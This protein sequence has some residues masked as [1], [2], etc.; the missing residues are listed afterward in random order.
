MDLINEL[1]ATVIPMILTAVIPYL[2]VLL[3][4]LIGKG[5]DFLESKTNNEYLLQVIEMAEQSVL[6]A[7]QTTLK[8]AKAAAKDGKL[9]KEELSQVKNEAKKQAV[10]ALN[11]FIDGLPK[12]AKKV[13]KDKAESFV[14][15]AIPKV[16]AKQMG[17]P[18]DPTAP[19]L[20]GK[21]TL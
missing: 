1:L 8:S 3:G 12:L 17:I 5:F 19:G 15:G 6:T 10:K 20:G 11:D 21:L 2:G 18:V 16:K 9:S 13:L 14:E 7:Y 4:K